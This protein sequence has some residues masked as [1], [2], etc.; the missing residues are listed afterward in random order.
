MPG[1]TYASQSTYRYGF[2]GQEKSDEIAL[3]DLDF[4]ARI[5]DARIGRFLSVDPLASSFPWQSPYCAMDNDPINKNDPTGMAASK[6][7]DWVRTTSADGKTQNYEWKDKVTSQSTAGEGET[8]LGKEYQYTAAD[9]REINLNTDKT[10]SD[11]SSFNKTITDGQMQSSD[12][13]QNRI[14]ELERKNLNSVDGIVLH[15]TESSNTKGTLNA[16]KT[17]RDGV[18]YGTHF[19]VGKDGEILQTAN[20]DKYTLHVGKTRLSTYPKNQNSVGIEVVG[21]YDYVNKVW[22]PLTSQQVTAVTNLT[23]YLMVTYKVSSTALYCHD[24]I[25]YKTDGEGTMVLDAIKGGII[26]K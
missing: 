14:S 6:P 24:K 11:V 20:L 16:F 3:G 2:N 13:T 19:L 18:N 21:K 1:R 8:W 25:S 7:D 22:E 15:R 12:I 17:G 4:G 10:W 26:K 9:G 23:N 5:Y